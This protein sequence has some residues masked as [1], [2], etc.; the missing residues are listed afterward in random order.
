MEVLDALTPVV[1]QAFGIR[2]KVDSRVLKQLEIVPSPFAKKGTNNAPSSG[3]NRWV[4]GLGLGLH[5]A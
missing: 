4:P 2:M 1:L 5:L 3:L